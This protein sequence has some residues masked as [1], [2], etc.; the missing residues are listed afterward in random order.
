MARDPTPAPRALDADE[1][2]EVTTVPVEAA[3]RMIDTG[4]IVDAGTLIALLRYRLRETAG[5]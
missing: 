3:Y 4:A 5:P 2:I 1:H